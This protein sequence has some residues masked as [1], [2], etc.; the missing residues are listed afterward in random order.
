MVGYANVA[1][2]GFGESFSG[3]PTAHLQQGIKDLN[4]QDQ[5]PDLD[6]GL[7]TTRYYR[8]TTIYQF[9]GRDG[10]D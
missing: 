7:N 10:D 3:G 8:K 4:L 6:G 9:V 2:K 5:D 1:L